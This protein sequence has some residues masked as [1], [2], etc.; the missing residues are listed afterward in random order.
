MPA[1]HLIVPF[2][3]AMAEGAARAL[4]TL[5]LPRLARLLAA[6]EPGARSGG[7]EYSLSPPHERAWADAVG[8]HGE[9]GALPLAALAAA[10]DGVTVGDAAVG[11]V[12]PVHWHVGRDQVTLADPDALAL[13]DAESRAVFDA[14]RGLFESEGYVM[15]WGSATRWYACHDELDGLRCASLDRVIGR[16]VDLWLSPDPRARRVSRLQSE[17]QMLLHT[18]P[19]NAA[20]EERGEAPVNSFWISGCGRAQPART[21]GVGVDSRLRAPALHG[22]WPAWADA[23]RALDSGPVAERLARSDRGEAVRLTLCGERFAQ[24]CNAVPRPLWKRLASRWQPAAAAALL[25]AL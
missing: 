22:D 24:T 6:L 11:L 16:N 8:L 12:T 9:D 5:A 14:V 13:P 20:R 2:A 1:M 15:H 17:A 18:H 25:E 3:G 7:D 4:R 10:A 23:W 19:L 21:D